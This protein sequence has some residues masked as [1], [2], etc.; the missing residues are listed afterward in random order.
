MIRPG[1]AWLR[2]VLIAW[3][4]LQS[5]ALFCQG[6]AESGARA[7]QIRYTISLVGHQEHLL[8]IQLELPPGA[9][10]RQVQL[11]VWN[12]LY[13]VRDFSQ[14]VNWVKAKR[15]GGEALAIQKVDKNT[16]QIAGAGEG[17][18]LE[19]EVFADQPGPYGAQVNPSHAFLNLAEV[20]MYPVGGR[21][22][23]MRLRFSDVPPDWKVATALPSANDG[24]VA[25]S[26]DRL[27]DSPVE[28][29]TFQESDFDE[30]GGH[31]RV[32]VDAEGS[33]Y[34]MQKIVADLRKIVAAATTW[35]EDR[36]V[37]RRPS[38]STR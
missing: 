36:P 9:P 24:Y 1:R 26:Y 12:A 5:P 38:T 32:V 14:F 18:V 13:Q 27:V 22:V 28:A 16:W 2:L 29:G 4:C 33:D 6:S 11:P 23:Q 21:S 19:Y 30:G 35:M 34:D 3:A 15:P 7:P 25:E 31:Y 37:R 17:A 20:L 10:Q 8:N